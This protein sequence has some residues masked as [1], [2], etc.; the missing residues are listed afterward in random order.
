MTQH[1]HDDRRPKDEAGSVLAAIP[2]LAVG[3]ALMFLLVWTTLPDMPGVEDWGPWLVEV[4][5]YILM[6]LG[7]VCLVGNHFFPN[8]AANMGE[9][10]AI[11]VATLTVLMLLATMAICLYVITA[12]LNA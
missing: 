7:I 12:G 9:R 3:A 1:I 5:P 4:G 10:T 8:I 2:F 6:G 11:A